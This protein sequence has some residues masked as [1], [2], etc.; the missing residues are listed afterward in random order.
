M[1]QIIVV[2]VFLLTN[3]YS[4]GW[5]KVKLAVDLHWKVARPLIPA[6]T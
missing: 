1:K 3:L 6:L 2:L 4:A 5:Q